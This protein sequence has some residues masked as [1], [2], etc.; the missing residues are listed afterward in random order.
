[1]RIIGFDQNTA[2]GQIII[3]IRNIPLFCR[4]CIR[5]VSMCAD[6]SLR[7]TP[8]DSRILRASAGGGCGP[9]GS[10]SR[11]KTTE[12]HFADKH[13]F[14][15]IFIEDTPFRHNQADACFCARL[16][17]HWLRPRYSR[18]AKCK[19]A[20]F[21]P[22]L[23]DFDFAQDTPARQKASELAFALAYSYL[24]L[25]LRYFRLGNAQI[26]LASGSAYPTLASPK[27][28]PLGKMQASLLLP[29]LI[30]IFARI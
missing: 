19:R 4:F 12:G 23:F 26:N 8:G 16:F 22:R 18:S 11:S 29:S 2:S 3:L 24:W 20:C 13:M 1:M 7:G 30:R 17:I 6:R 27:I 21:C 25:R 28:L 5:P 10:E 14:R 15:H 9:R